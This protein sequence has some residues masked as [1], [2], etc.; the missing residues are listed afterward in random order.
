MT[1]ELS[2]RLRPVVAVLAAKP[3]AEPPPTGGAGMWKVAE[4]I[5]AIVAQTR[6]MQ[7][8]IVKCDPHLVEILKDTY[9]G[10]GHF[11]HL[12][13]RFWICIDVRADVPM[14]EIE[15]LI[16]HSYDLIVRG[17]TRKQRAGLA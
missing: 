3:G 14:D 15:R 4:K 7:G 13:R 8:V 5:F 6:N 2:A 12:D 9:A 10:V 11:G 17:L 1:V 16:G